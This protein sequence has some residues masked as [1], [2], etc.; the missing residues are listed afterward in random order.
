M[1]LIDR[2]AC[3][4]RREERPRRHNLLTALKGL[5]HPQERFLHYVLGL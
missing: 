5:M 3:G 1:Q 2:E 4:H